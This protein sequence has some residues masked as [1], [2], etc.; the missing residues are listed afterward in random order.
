MYMSP[1]KIEDDKAKYLERAEP[2]LKELDQLLGKQ[3]YL[4][5]KNLTYNDFIFFEILDVN[6]LFLPDILAKYAN[7]KK[8]H[9]RIGNLKG[10][11]EY[12]Q[13]DRNPK[14]INGATAKWG[15]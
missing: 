3:D 11:K 7:L 4:I 1:N 8:F 12:M 14:K 10:V 9:E 13:S 6:Q 15:G 2:V 5:G